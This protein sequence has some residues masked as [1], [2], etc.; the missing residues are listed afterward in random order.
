MQVMQATCCCVVR[1][2]IDG[3][4]GSV[5]LLSAPSISL[6]MFSN[7]ATYCMSDT[8]LRIFI[9]FHSQPRAS[10]VD[11]TLRRVLGGASSLELH[12]L[13]VGSPRPRRSEPDADLSRR[14]RSCRTT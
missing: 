5:M 12:T 8:V 11:V 13:R 4:A 10:H 9:S 7:P 6:C 1:Q 2:L 14:S 3:L